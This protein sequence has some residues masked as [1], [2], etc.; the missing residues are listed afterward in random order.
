MNKKT[1]WSIV[2]LVGF[3]IMAQLIADIGATKFVVVGPYV[4]PAGTFIFALTFTLRDLVHK[5]LGKEWAKVAIWVA[6]G[7]N[8]VL[9]GYLYL[10]TFLPAPGFFG[11]AESWNAIF[12]IVPSITIASIVAELV[13]E[14]V[15][16]EIYSLWKAKMPKAPQWSR[17]LVSNIISLPLDS[18]IFATLAFVVLPKFFGGHEETFMLALSLTVGQTIWKAI[19]TVVSMPGIYLVKDK[20]VI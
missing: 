15:D 12:A 14:L 1:I 16:T 7:C 8:L 18:F 9:A 4:L 5:R 6:A 20:S 2:A 19:V 13:S 3:Y 10:M 17:V 11:L